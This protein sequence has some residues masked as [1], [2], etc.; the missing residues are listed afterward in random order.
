[1]QF[2]N[3]H[4]TRRNG[5]VDDPLTFQF[6]NQNGAGTAVAFLASL[7]G[8]DELL[9]APEIIQDWHAGMG[10]TLPFFVVENE[11][12]LRRHKNQLSFAS[13]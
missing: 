13:R 7:L 11:M 2:A 9:L 1:M 8:T 4:Q 6:P 10:G 5:F 3:R 12:G